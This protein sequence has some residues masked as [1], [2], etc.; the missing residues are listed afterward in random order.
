M[1]GFMAYGQWWRDHRRVFWQ[2]MNQH[3]IEVYRPVQVAVIRK[4][5]RKLLKTPDNF[6]QLIRLCVVRF[7]QR[8]LDHCLTVGRAVIARS[9]P[10]CSG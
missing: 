8:F 7:P 4:L 5:L 2:H 1:F 10:R 6:K 9:R 3:A